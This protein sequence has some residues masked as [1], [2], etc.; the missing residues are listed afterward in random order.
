MSTPPWHL[1]D[2]R[3]IATVLYF[4]RVDHSRSYDQTQKK[5][6]SRRRK[7]PQQALLTFAEA[8]RLFGN[9]NVERLL[10]EPLENNCFMFKTGMRSKSTLITYGFVSKETLDFDVATPFVVPEHSVQFFAEA[11]VITRAGPPAI[12]KIPF[13]KTPENDYVGRQVQVIRKDK[14]K[15]YEGRIIKL[16]D[17][18]NTKVEV[19]LTA[20]LAHAKGERAVIPLSHLCD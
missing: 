7:R 12:Q 19:Q 9:A 1:V 5:G 2:K 6:C 17:S 14:F 16:Y 10:D 4:P 3:N 13:G 11:L 18:D 20:K 15:M 8:V